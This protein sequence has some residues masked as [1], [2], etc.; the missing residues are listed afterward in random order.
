MRIKKTGFSEHYNEIA[1]DQSRIDL[2]ETND[3]TVVAL[4]AVM[5]TDYAKRQDYFGEFIQHHPKA[6]H[7]LKGLTTHH[8][9]RF[10]NVW[11][12]GKRYLA[13][14]RGH[15]AAII[16]GTTVDW[17]KGRAMRIYSLYEIFIKEEI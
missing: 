15:V 1:R 10:N 16:D 9:E 4:A 6:H 13:F 12:N 2:K 8:P 11:K 3:C 5:G 7:V 14:T 17:T